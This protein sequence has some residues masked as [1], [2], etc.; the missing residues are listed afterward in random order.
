MRDFGL[1]WEDQSVR[2]AWYRT[3]LCRPGMDTCTNPKET[4]IRIIG[5]YHYFVLEEKVNTSRVEGRLLFRLGMRSVSSFPIS[6]DQCE[7]WIGDWGVCKEI[8]RVFPLDCGRIDT[9]QHH[10]HLGWR[11]KVFDF[12]L[13]STDQTTRGQT[14]VWEP[15]KKRLTTSIHRHCHN[16]HEEQT[17]NIGQIK[18]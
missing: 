7:H 8:V 17:W 5:R 10:I 18:C 13:T 16:Q 15:R 2:V 12:R 4:E 11:L 6:E 1:D 14:S 9:T 3:V